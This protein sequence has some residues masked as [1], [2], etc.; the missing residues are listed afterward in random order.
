MNKMKILGK[1]EKK[2]TKIKIDIFKELV[3]KESN[4][5]GHTKFESIYKQ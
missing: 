4:V 1:K 2:S 3:D 5:V